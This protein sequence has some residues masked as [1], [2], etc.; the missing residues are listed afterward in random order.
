MTTLGFY[1]ERLLIH[2]V[3]RAS[4]ASNGAKGDPV[5]GAT[6]TF[7][8]RVEKKS[9]Y[10][11]GSDGAL[12]RYEYRMATNTVVKLDD[13]FWFPSVGG[14]AADDTSSANNARRPV[15]LEIASDAN[16][17]RRGVMVFF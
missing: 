9:G 5:P 10:V 6:S 17:S 12:V 13:I 15:S 4:R 1:P 14:E 8:A 7:K 2:T 11:R 16:G 3:T